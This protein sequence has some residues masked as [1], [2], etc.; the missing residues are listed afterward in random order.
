[1]NIVIVGA[2]EVGTHIASQLV[3]E[4][5]DVVIIEKDPECAAKASNMLDCLVITGRLKCRYS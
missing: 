3:A 4:Q 1:M 2:G 5:K